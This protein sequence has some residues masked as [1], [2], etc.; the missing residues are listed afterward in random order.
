MK[1]VPNFH[2]KFRNCL[3]FSMLN[4]FVMI[5]ATNYKGVG[6]MILLIVYFI[7]GYWSVG[8]T[9]YG[10]LIAYTDGFNLFLKKCVYAIFL[11]WITIP[12]ALLKMLFGK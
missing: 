5:K 10:N 4:F 2:P 11:G 6:R 1:T 3:L 7:L 12:W 9:I 8:R